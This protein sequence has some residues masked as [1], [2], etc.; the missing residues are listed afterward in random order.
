MERIKNYVNRKCIDAMIKW[1]DFK[2]SERGDTN[3]LSI[4]II[5]IIVVGFAALFLTVGQ[6]V[7]DKVTEK[8][9]TFIESL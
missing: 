7:M 1:N 4:L 2:T 6:G 8:V 5:L 3:F 9:Q